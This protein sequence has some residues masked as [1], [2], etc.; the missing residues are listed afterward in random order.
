M[1]KTSAE[2]DQRQR[3]AI[4]SAA[5]RCFARNGFHATSMHDIIAEAGVSASTV[6][7]HF[8][9]KEDVIYASTD[10]KFGDIA[11]RIDELMA[12]RPLPPPS[13]VL[14][15]IVEHLYGG[16][17]GGGDESGINLVLNAWA[18]AGR[19]SRLRTRARTAHERLRG[20][21]NQ[22]VQKYRE[23]GML[24][25]DVDTDT[26]TEILWTLAV[27]LFPRQALLDDDAVA[28]SA[29]LLDHLLCPE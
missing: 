28:R 6:Y 16:L 12:R 24:R 3:S 23:A 7:R 20:E 10:E 27:A 18:E 21:I 25:P 13:A 4:V 1:P 17:G 8:H 22:M 15:T 5:Q 14:C 19:A 26:A 29:E 2:Y 9:G 11:V